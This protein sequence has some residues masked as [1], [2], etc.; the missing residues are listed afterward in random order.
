MWGTQSELTF[1]DNLG[2]WKDR[3]KL[4]LTAATK[5]TL[6]TGYRQGLMLRT[7]WREM[8]RAELLAHVDE[9]LAN[10]RAMDPTKIV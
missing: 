6:L 2:N 1:V 8:S 5:I 7:E 4:V 3:G 10:Y 9:Q